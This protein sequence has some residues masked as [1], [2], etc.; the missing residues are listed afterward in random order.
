MEENAKKSVCRS[1]LTKKFGQ[2]LTT[3]MPSVSLSKCKYTC[4]LIN[5]DYPMHSNFRNLK[6]SMKANIWVMR[7]PENFHGFDPAGTRKRCDQNSLKEIIN[8]GHHIRIERG[9]LW[10]KKN[11]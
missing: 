5:K 9:R 10:C 4:S 1:T 11:I 6:I 3:M 7:E 8:R 2:H